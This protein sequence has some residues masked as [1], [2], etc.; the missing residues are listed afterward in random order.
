MNQKNFSI[1]SRY[2]KWKKENVTKEWTFLLSLSLIAISVA[3][4]GMRTGIPEVLGITFLFG[5]AIFIKS[6]SEY[7]KSW[8]TSFN[9]DE[10]KTIEFFKKNG[11]L[12]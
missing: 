9:K 2:V 7:L 6:I 12:K 4:L 8:Y 10:I 1:M 5:F 3:F 11:F